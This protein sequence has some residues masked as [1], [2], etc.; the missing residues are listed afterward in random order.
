MKSTSGSFQMPGRKMARKS[1]S[2]VHPSRKRQQKQEE[3]PSIVPQVMKGNFTADL[4]TIVE[5]AS[6]PE[7]EDTD[8]LLVELKKK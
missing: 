7:E 3:N 5:N 1:T 4:T 2:K 8:V 6:L